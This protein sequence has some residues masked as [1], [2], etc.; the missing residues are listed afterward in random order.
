MPCR[1][2]GRGERGV[3]LELAEVYIAGLDRQAQRRRGFLPHRDDGILDA[4][5]AET[6]VGGESI[7]GQRLF[8]LVEAHPEIN[9]RLRLGDAV[10]VGGHHELLR[11]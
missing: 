10:A 5:S 7:D 6:H 1:V 3:R 9:V 2:T 8:L 4:E 11:G